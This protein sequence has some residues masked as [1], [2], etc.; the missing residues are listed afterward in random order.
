[1]LVQA[2]G[3]GA[4]LAASCASTFLLAEAGLL[5]GRRATTTWWLA[6]VWLIV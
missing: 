4:A 6:A 3:A 1:M 5:N 2:F